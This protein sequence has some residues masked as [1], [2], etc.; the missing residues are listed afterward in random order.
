MKEKLQKLIK[1]QIKSV[2]PSFGAALFLVILAILVADLFYHEKPMI[3]RGYEIKIAADGSVVKRK[4]KKTID[5][6]TAMKTADATRGAKLFRK[7][8]SCHS[9]Q[10]GGGNKVGPNLY[11][12]IGRT[13]GRAPG[14]KYSEALLAKGG[15]WSKKSI[16]EFITKP[17]AYIKGT[18]MAFA[19]LKKPQA[20]ADVILFLEENSKK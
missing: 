2:G 19:G 20:R 10:K 3:K 18:K 14:F 7:C 4:P 8:A 5:L 9:A 11:K 17:K 15:S 12:V 13:K 16:N 1:E 6:A